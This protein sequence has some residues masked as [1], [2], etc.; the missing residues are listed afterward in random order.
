MIPNVKIILMVGALLVSAGLSS[1]VTWRYQD[2]KMTAAISA[3]RYEAADNAIKQLESIN[4]GI[5][6]AQEKFRETTAQQRLA[7]EKLDKSLAALGSTTNG[8]RGELSH[9]PARVADATR[10]ALVAYSETCT[11]IF[12]DMAERGF[13]LA[14]IGAGIAKAADGHSA[15]AEHLRDAWPSTSKGKQ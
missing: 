11:T 5:L 2:M 14:E 8:L 13:R 1:F 6:D 3:V 10:P 15:D 9:L 12:A 7:G 4:K